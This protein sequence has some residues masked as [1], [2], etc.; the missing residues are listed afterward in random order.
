MGR[1]DGEGRGVPEGFLERRQERRRRASAVGFIVWTSSTAQ[2]GEDGQ[3][4]VEGGWSR[5]SCDPVAVAEWGT[6]CEFCVGV[7]EALC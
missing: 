6:R 3:L 2:A 1:P 5:C 4:L 7:R